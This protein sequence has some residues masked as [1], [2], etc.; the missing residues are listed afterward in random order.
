MSDSDA[1]T[2][3]RLLRRNART[4]A[5][6]RARGVAARVAHEQLRERVVAAQP[7][8][9]VHAQGSRRCSGKTVSNSTAGSPR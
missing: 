9:E 1:T 5:Q 8:E 4:L 6:R 2:L 3:P 7:L